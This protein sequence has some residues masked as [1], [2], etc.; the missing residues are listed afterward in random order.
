M[1]EMRSF[2]RAVRIAGSPTPRMEMSI[3]AARRST[4]V[5]SSARAVWSAR[6]L[7]RLLKSR[8]ALRSTS[9]RSL[10][11][12]QA[13]DSAFTPIS[14]AARINSMR[15]DV[16]PEIPRGMGWA[17]TRSARAGADQ[18]AHRA[19]H[20]RAPEGLRQR[21]RGAEGRRLLGGHAELRAEVRGDGDDRD[22]R[23]DPRDLG[24][25]R[26]APASRHVDVGDGARRPG[27]PRVADR[28]G[29]LRGQPHAIPGGLEPLGHEVAQDRVVL[30]HED[31]RGFVHGRMMW[32][33]QA[34]SFQL[35]QW[36]WSVDTL[37]S[38]RIDTDVNPQATDTQAHEPHVLVVDDD[39]VIRQMVADYLVKHEC[40]A[41]PVAD[42][43]AMK[44][45]LAAEVVDLIVLDLKLRT[46]DGMGLARALRDDSTIPIIM[47]T[48]RADEADRVMGFELG[49]DDYRTNPFSPP[50]L[51]ARIRTVLRR[52]HAE[53]RQGRPEGIRAYRFDGWEL[54]LN[55]RRLTAPGGK[56]V[57]L[58]NG[59]FSLLVVLLGA[60]NRILSRDQLLDLS[61]LHNDEAYNR[62]IDVQ[63][64]RIR[65]KIAKDAAQPRYIRTERGAGYI[66]GV[67]VVVV[68]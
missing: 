56:V 31:S 43:R 39:P 68:Y 61:R 47:L 46:E 23:I 7:V 42:G 29:A 5:D 50:E 16:M 65:R 51:L 12:S 40:R 55:T 35:K 21:S 30:D 49:A 28:A 52:R 67:P 17:R 32:V 36:C 57:A 10:R 2:R 6:S 19:D 54:N 63:I 15:R 59:E 44:E 26:G 1:P 14:T 20:V 25:H 27:G 62:S 38:M 4:S 41:T 8:S 60:A 18:L 64:L 9:A 53:V 66:F 33:S 37:H 3:A 24:D 34:S 13:A 45:V 11:M 48:G 22:V 58:S